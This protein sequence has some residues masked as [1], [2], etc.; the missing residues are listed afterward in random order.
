[1]GEPTSP[2]ANKIKEWG[3]A[4]LLTIILGGILALFLSMFRPG[5]L[6]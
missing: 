6:W 2:K 3:L 1:M 4:V 5:A